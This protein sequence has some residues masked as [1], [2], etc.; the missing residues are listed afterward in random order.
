QERDARRRR[1]TC[2]RDVDAVLEVGGNIL[3]DVVLEPRGRISGVGHGDAVGDQDAVVLADRGGRTRLS[4][5]VHGAVGV[6]GRLPHAAEGVGDRVRRV[7]RATGGDELAATEAVELGAVIHD[8]TGERTGAEDARNR[9]GAPGALSGRGVGVANQVVN[10]RSDTTDGAVAGR[11]RRRVRRGLA[12][13]AGAIDEGLGGDVDAG[14][15]AG[16]E[17]AVRF[18]DR[19]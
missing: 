4:L 6:A 17:D 5:E 9:A 10:H 12:D 7:G 18:G 1:D 8:V 14:A 2:D 3:R 13:G 16:I 19:V 11:R 15:F